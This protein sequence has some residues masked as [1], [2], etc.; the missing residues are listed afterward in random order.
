MTRWSLPAKS[1]R[2]KNQRQLEDN[3]MGKYF[4]VT[5]PLAAMLLLIVNAGGIRTEPGYAIPSSAT[6][7]IKRH[8]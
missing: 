7:T 8:H 4:A 6:S 3:A 5:F 1:R 2:H